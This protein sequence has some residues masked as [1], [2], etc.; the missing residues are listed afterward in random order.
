MLNPFF[1][2]APFLY[3]LKKSENRKFFCFQ[4]VEKGCIGNECVKLIF[5]GNTRVYSEPCQI[6]KMERFVRTV[7][8]FKKAFKRCFPVNLVKFLRKPVLQMFCERLLQT[9]NV[10]TTS[11]SHK[12]NITSFV[13]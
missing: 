10:L 3:P 11:F 13:T 12:R 5:F 9:I 8:G 4:G 2:N 6:S 7:Y 1:P